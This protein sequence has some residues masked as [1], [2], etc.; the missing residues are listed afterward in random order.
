MAEELLSAAQV[1]AGIHADV[2]G[3]SEAP[4]LAEF[5]QLVAVPLN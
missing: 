3:L 2:T 5:I 4:T 1:G